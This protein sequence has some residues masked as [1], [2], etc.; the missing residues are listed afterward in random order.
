M[1]YRGGAFDL[2]ICISTIEHIGRDNT[3][4]GLPG[5]T[6]ASG[7]VETIR[8]IERVLEPNGRLL[9]TVPFGRREE[10][11]WFIQYD[12]AEWQKLLANTSFWVE[13]QT[14]FRLDAVGWQ[15]TDGLIGTETLRY[16]KDGAPAAQGVLCASLRKPG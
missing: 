9:I 6:G 12:A 15:P 1:P 8:E 10:H 7:D 3:G 2:V 16:A 4:Y 5:H 13:E 14:V 11:S